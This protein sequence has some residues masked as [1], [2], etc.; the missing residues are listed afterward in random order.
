[1][2]KKWEHVPDVGRKELPV[3]RL[4]RYM[5]LDACRRMVEYGEVRVSSSTSLN[6]ETLT[7]TRRDDEQTQSIKASMSKVA[8]VGDVPKGFQVDVRTESG[9]GPDGREETTFRTRVE[10]S[11]WILS[12]TT[13]LTI[14]LFDEFDEIAAVEICDPERL[15]ALLESASGRLL[16]DERDIFAHDFVEYA[17][18]YLVYGTASLPMKPFMRKSVA[19]RSQKE[20][21][22]V[23]HPRRQALKHDWLYVGLLWDVARVV[24]REDVAAGRIGEVRFPEDAAAR[25]RKS[26]GAPT[27]PFGTRDDVIR[28]FEHYDKRRRSGT[29]TDMPE[30]VES[31]EPW[32]GTITIEYIKVHYGTRVLSKDYV[33]DWWDYRTHD[34]DIEQFEIGRQYPEQYSEFRLRFE[35]DRGGGVTFSLTNPHAQAEIVQTLLTDK[36]MTFGLRYEEYRFMGST[37]ER[38]VLV[39]PSGNEYKT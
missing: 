22:V 24:T 32:T 4:Y 34:D 17:D 38:P 13:D 31:K 19:Y 5:P 28:D 25:Y 8:G 37:F 11:F 20:F 23:W 12:L 2:L 18:H 33:A 35:N 39:M 21:R 27:G 10:D 30:G 29:V 7:E 26:R 3:K 16:I 15:L 14:D 9:D 1:M 36:R 6:D